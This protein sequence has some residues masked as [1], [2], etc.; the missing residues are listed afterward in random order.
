MNDLTFTSYF[1]YCGSGGGAYGF[2][3]AGTHLLGRQLRMEV[4]GG[5]D[6]DPKAVQNFEYLTGVPA[7]CADARALTKEQLRASAQNRNPD[8]VFGSAPCV[9]A[10]KLIT[11]A[12]AATPHYQQMNE[13]MLVWTEQMLD[14]WHPRLII[15]ENVGNVIHRAKHVIKKV[16]AMLKKAGY[17]VA[18]EDHELGEYGPADVGGV[19]YDAGKLGGLAQRRKRWLLVARDPALCAPLLY[20]PPKRR[21]RGVGEVIGPLPLPDDPAG[22]PMHKLPRLSV[23]NWIRLALIPAGGD[24]R[25]LPGVLAEEQKR[26]EVF[27]RTHLARWEDPSV[28]V[29]GPGS[30]GPYGVAAPRV[31]PMMLD[32][33]AQKRWEQH[34]EKTEGGTHWFKG[35]YGVQPWDKPGRAVIGGNGNGSAYVADPRVIPQPDNA[36]AFEHKYRVEDWQEPSHAVTGTDR[37]GSGAPSVAD[38]RIAMAFDHAHRVTPWESPAGTVTHSPSPASG[39]GACADPRLGCEPHSGAYGVNGWTDPANTVTGAGQVDNARQAV[40]DPRAEG[41]RGVLGVVPWDVESGTITGATRA[42]NGPFSVADPRVPNAFDRGYAVVDWS[43]PV[44]TVAGDQSPG[45]GTY[46]VADPRPQAP[47]GW[48]S[49]DDMMVFLE[50]PGPWAIVDK[51]SD[52]PPLTIITDLKKPSPLP[53]RIVARDGTWH[54]PFT[55]LEVGCLQ[56][57]PPMLRGAPLQLSG[58]T[59]TDRKQ[60]G[61]LVPPPAAMAIADRML[62]ALGEGALGVFSLSGAGGVWVDGEMVAGDA[63]Q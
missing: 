28:T 10:T 63:L 4:L 49:I 58:P 45:C 33:E 59:T 12:L 5:F 43:S 51:S 21:V 25:D 61:N 27:R 1:A 17:L 6:I 11:D 38:P 44:N 19:M 62:V 3:Q 56:G 14:T 18:D 29:G 34:G 32:E 16:R 47:A 24:W 2:Q 8:V 30:N 60:I 41:F 46:T 31:V 35:K 26:R 52:G 13:L 55:A 22:G 23:M 48:L 57:L 54:R 39:G 9:G 40:A 15:Y 42:G 37:L 36:R 53:V 20:K 7:L 50:T